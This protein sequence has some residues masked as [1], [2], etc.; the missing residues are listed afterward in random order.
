MID[1]DRSKARQMFLKINFT[2]KKINHYLRLELIHLRLRC[3]KKWI[4]KDSESR[5][6]IHLSVDSFYKKNL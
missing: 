2:K 3:I 4:V 5:F 6:V 1:Y